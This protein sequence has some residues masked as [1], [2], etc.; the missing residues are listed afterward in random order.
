MYYINCLHVVICR[1]QAAAAP[2]AR[3]TTVG[4]LR[5][6]NRWSGN[7]SGN[8]EQRS[9]TRVYT[10]RKKG[11]CHKGKRKREKI[12]RRGKGE[13]GRKKG[14]KM[15]GIYLYVPPHSV[16][17]L[18]R[19]LVRPLFTVSSSYSYSFFL[20]STNLLFLFG[21]FAIPFFFWR[22]FIFFLGHP[23]TGHEPRS[24]KAEINIPI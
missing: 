13:W 8:R 1:H 11:N 20:P 9:E 22:I 3:W 7:K 21:L 24:L 2:V 4:C 19:L 23:R 15:T 16:F 6:I 10:N 5:G 17:F 18:S 14:T 12:E